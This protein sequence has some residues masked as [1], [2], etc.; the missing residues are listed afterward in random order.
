M[1]ILKYIAWGLALFFAGSWTFNLSIRPDLR[2]KSHVVAI[3]IWWTEIVLAALGK[4]S[5]FHLFWL[6]PISL[7]IPQ[8]VQLAEFK[9]RFAHAPI[10]VIFVKS[11]IPVALALAALIYFSHV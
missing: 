6:M 2:L 3:I 1:V 5:V 4:Y 9:R 7:Y 10:A 11:A 8:V